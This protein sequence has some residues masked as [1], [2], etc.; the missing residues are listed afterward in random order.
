MLHTCFR[1]VFAKIAVLIWVIVGVDQ[2]LRQTLI[3]SPSEVVDQYMAA[4]T[5]NN[6]IQQQEAMSVKEM[7]NYVNEKCSY[8]NSDAQNKQIDM[9][10]LDT[11]FYLRSKEVNVKNVLL[12]IPQRMASKAAFEVIN[13]VFDYPCYKGTRGKLRDCAV[14]KKFKPDNQTMKVVFTRHPFDRLIIEFRH[15]KSIETEPNQSKRK[16]LFSR[17]RTWK[18]KGRKGS[19]QFR[20]FINQTVLAH[21][22]TILPVSK[23]CN[24]CGQKY[25]VVY[26]LDDGL[27]S[28]EEIIQKAGG[29]IK[30]SAT[31]DSKMK[32]VGTRVQRKFFSEVTADE[33]ELLYNKFKEDFLLFGYSLDF[34]KNKG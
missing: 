15:Q 19:H 12:C 24:V 7:S 4:L 27:E 23:V 5:H 10:Q 21:N 25:D 17:H 29:K 30:H 26:N 3:Q 32:V 28:I 34:Y 13:E 33:I 18:K 20:E 14:S 1:S 8:N 6:N 16:L 31:T 9:T 11:Y 2:V 22:S